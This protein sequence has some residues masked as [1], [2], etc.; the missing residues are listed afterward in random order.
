MLR[1]P[2]PLKGTLGVIERPETPS[3]R[4]GCVEDG[5]LRVT[6]HRSR[7]HTAR[8]PDLKRTRPM[9]NG[10]CFCKSVRYSID[11]AEYQSVDCHCSMCRRAHSAPYV[12]WIVVPVEK[13]RYTA[14]A[15]TT[16]KSSKNG[17]RCFCKSC[18]THV[19]CVSTEHPEVID[20]PVGSLDDPGRCPPTIEIFADTKL[21]WVHGNAV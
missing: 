13:F 6:F 7:L 17:T 19:A 16:L 9:L 4:Y 21:S 15:P 14:E 2:A 10:G 5:I 18:G 8:N 1:T 12:T 11:E 3:D 20:I